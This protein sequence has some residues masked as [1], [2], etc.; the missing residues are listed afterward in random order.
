MFATNR[1]TIWSVPSSPKSRTTLFPAR[2]A[3]RMWANASLPSFIGFRNGRRSSRPM[4]RLRPCKV[5]SWARSEPSISIVASL[6]AEIKSRP[7]RV[8]AIS[9]SVSTIGAVRSWRATIR[10]SGVIMPVSR[11]NGL[12]S[13]FFESK[14]KISTFPGKKNF[15]P[16]V[17]SVALNTPYSLCMSKMRTEPTSFERI[18]AHTSLFRIDLHV[19]RFDARDRA[20]RRGRVRDF[21]DPL[22]VVPRCM[23]A[24]GEVRRDRLR[25]A[26]L[27]RLPVHEL[28]HPEF[29]LAVED[30]AS[31][32]L[33]RLRARHDHVGDRRAGE[34][35]RDVALLVYD[36]LHEAIEVVSCALDDDRERDLQFLRIPELELRHE[37]VDDGRGDDLPDLHRKSLATLSRYSWNALRFRPSTCVSPSRIVRTSSPIR[38]AIFITLS[39]YTGF[40]WRTVTAIRCASIRGHGYPTDTRL[41]PYDESW[42]N[43]SSGRSRNVPRSTRNH[44]LA[45]GCNRA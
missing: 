38:S 11:T 19:E 20:Q 36:V 40:S 25:L 39:W 34:L 32:P 44:F 24:R 1:Y 29:R 7:P 30:R 5:I 14:E 37:A 2:I 8:F 43:A 12:A 33:V 28:D 23:S 42:P 17:L 22:H 31:I 41:L 6:T 35:V 18:P 26:E 13:R 15:R 45:R 16:S 27:L 21:V 10:S 3:A 9:Y 4:R